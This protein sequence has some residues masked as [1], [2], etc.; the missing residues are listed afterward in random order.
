MAITIGQLSQRT[1]VNIETIRY[2]ERIWLMPKARRAPNGRRVYADADA[3]R[4][5]FVRHARGLGFDMP[6]IRTL[7][8]LQ[9]EPE[10]SCEEIANI[11][12]DQLAAIQDR[13]KRLQMLR[14]ELARVVRACAC[15]RVAD[16]RIVEALSQP[17]KSAVRSSI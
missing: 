5:T 4:L 2:Y 7:L 16:C 17:D 9:E 6:A 11:A 1:G 8:T 3:R 10:A 15:G 12:R 13:I 14:T